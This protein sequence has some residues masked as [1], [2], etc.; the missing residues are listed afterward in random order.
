MKAGLVLDRVRFE[1]P[2]IEELAS[3]GFHAVDMHFH[4]NHSDSRTTVRS[5]VVMARKMGI[6]LAITDHNAIS[7][8]FEAR[9]IAGAE[10]WI[11]PGMEVSTADGPHVLLFFYTADELKEFYQRDLE[12]KKGASPFQATSLSTF[13]LLDITEGY[14]CVRAAAT[15]TCFPGSRRSRCSVEEC[16]G[17]EI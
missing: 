14:N 16:D 6:G 10:P 9:R 5:A 11:V 3:F 15:R 12:K 7:G 8:V 1:R 17:R 2:V 13:D 4:T